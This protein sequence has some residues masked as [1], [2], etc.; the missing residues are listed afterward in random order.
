DP[1]L[2]MVQLAF[3]S[4]ERLDQYLHALQQVIDRH[5]ILRTAFVWEGVSMPAQVVWRHAR[6]PVIE[7]TLDAADGPIAEQLAR[8]FDPRHTRLDLTQAPLLHCAIAQDSEGR[9][10]LTQ[11]LHHLI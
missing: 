2:L 11:R 3:D 4:R 10:L 7:L 1:Y 6:L 9:W 8:R 5:D